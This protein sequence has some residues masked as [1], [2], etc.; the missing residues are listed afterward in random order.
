MALGPVIVPTL[1]AIRWGPQPWQLFDYKAHPVRDPGGNPCLVFAHGGGH[2]GGNYKDIWLIDGTAVQPYNV[3]LNFLL[4]PTLG[5]HFDIVSLESA[6]WRHTDA[7]AAG[8]GSVNPGFSPSQKVYF[9]TDGMND[10]KRG[11]AAV[12]A[13]GQGFNNSSAFRMN[14]DLF[15]GGGQSAGAVKSCLAQITGPL[16]FGNR[17]KTFASRITEAG[18]YDSSVNGLL[19]LQGQIDFRNKNYNGTT[20]DYSTGTD[21]KGYFGTRDDDGGADWNNLP[22]FLKAAI[23]IVAYLENRDLQYWKPLFNLQIE[24]GNHLLPLVNGHD[25]RQLRDLNIA[26]EGAGLKLGEDYDFV[27][28][29]TNAIE[30]SI[31]Q[32]THAQKIYG[33]M[34]NA[35]KK[36]NPASPLAL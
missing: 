3:L 5:T 31:I 22:Q 19:W 6:Q 16:T 28:P 32:A 23:S 10:Y 36:A 8:T 12:K 18:Q 29:I 25:S 20:T 7:D 27:P 21:Q 33:F 24:Q 1:S 4:T 11:V 30:G 17:Q 9:W 14:P 2:L 34:V 26:M 15:I 13:W 35:L